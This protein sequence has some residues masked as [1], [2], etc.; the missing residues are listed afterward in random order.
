MED[1]SDNLMMSQG[2][3]VRHCLHVMLRVCALV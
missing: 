2:L 3:N 1:L